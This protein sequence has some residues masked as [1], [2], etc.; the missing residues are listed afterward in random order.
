MLSKLMKTAVPCSAVLALLTVA[1]PA[2]AQ[3]QHEPIQGRHS[4]PI[5]PVNNRQIESGSAPLP[6]VDELITPPDSMPSAPDGEPLVEGEYALDDGY[7]VGEPGPFDA[8]PDTFIPNMLGDFVGGFLFEPTPAPDTDPRAV[9]RTLNRFKV[10]DNNSPIPRT[11]LLWSY[12]YFS[13]PFNV[14]GGAHR[15]FLGGEY[16]FFQQRFSVDARFNFNYFE[17]FPNSDNETLIGN[18]YTTLKALLLRTET[19]AIS[20][21][22]AFGWPTGDF[23][24]QL[25]TDNVY[26]MPF[27]S[28]LYHTPGSRLYA[29]GFE[30]LDIPSESN[31]EMMLHTDLGVG[32]F[33]LYDH[34]GWINSI[35]GTT[36]M[37]LYTPVG[38]AASGVYQGMAYDDVLNLTVGATAVIANRAT[39]AMGMGFPI[40]E[41]KDYDFEFQIH[42]NWYFRNTGPFLLDSV[43]PPG[44]EAPRPAS[45]VRL[46]W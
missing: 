30:Q 7:L 2:A 35:A 44:G 32:Y 20:S 17:G 23:P 40:S 12:N 11:R 19:L 5:V 21:G 36:E 43:V 33:L 14:S 26:F 39:L 29:Q 15:N 34:P 9:A 8:F 37:H 22:L 24:G 25:P 13:D 45:P 28:F 6:A 42:L 18:F 16:A 41:N 10:A 31:D 3:F 46:W 38:G 4:I 1:G 27:A